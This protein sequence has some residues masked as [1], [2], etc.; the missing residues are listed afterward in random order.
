M[1]ESDLMSR[2]NR[3]KAAQRYDFKYLS[4]SQDTGRVESGDE[5]NDVAIETIQAKRLDQIKEAQQGQQVR[6]LFIYPFNCSFI[7]LLLYSFV[8]SSLHSLVTG[9]P[10]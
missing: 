2:L 4:P 5:H 8:H 1:H 7:R 9:S 3:I 6:D 10:P